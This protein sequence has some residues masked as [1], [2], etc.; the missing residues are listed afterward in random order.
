[1]IYLVV[2]NHEKFYLLFISDFNFVTEEYQRVKRSQSGERHP[3]FQFVVNN[4]VEANKNNFIH[5]RVASTPPPLK[6]L[7]L[8]AAITKPM[9]IQALLNSYLM[10][11]RAEKN[12][13]PQTIEK[14]RECFRTWIIPHLGQKEIEQLDRLTILGFRHAMVER[15]LSISRQY[16]I[17][18]TL[19]SFIRF[20]RHVLK[21]P[22]FD[23]GEIP[24][25]NR[26]KPHV[27]TLTN[28]EIERLTT[29]IDANTFSGA[30][31]RALIELLLA[32]GLR[33]SEALSLN[34][35]V[36]DAGL[37]EVEI[38]G[39]GNKPRVVFFSRRAHFWIRHYMNKRFDDNAA[40]FVTT[41]IPARRLSRSDISRFFVHLRCR[42]GIEKKVTPHILRHTFCTN[43]LNNGADITFIRDLAGHEDIQTTAKY[44]LGVN[45]DQLRKV[46]DRFLDYGQ[47]D[48]ADAGIQI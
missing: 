10:F 4:F 2:L 32:T 22:V 44:Y 33:I 41:G 38:I 11:C 39:K 3:L 25:P 34:R 20:C 5:R 9:Q 48:R 27:V 47:S 42:A 37:N 13:S 15:R 35:D 23:P 12:N 19:K 7:S 40:L 8:Y 21:L 14:Y 26:G 29:H 43:L 16:S 31:L 24:L 36:F 17:L 18:I 45:K 30:R 28:D 1:M 46:V 6:Q